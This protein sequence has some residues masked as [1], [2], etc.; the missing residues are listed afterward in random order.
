MVIIYIKK[1]ILYTY[2]KKHPKTQSIYESDFDE[3][4]EF[5]QDDMYKYREIL[6]VINSLKEPQRQ[7]MILR[8][9][10]DFTFKEIGEI[11][12]KSENYCRV[13]FFREKKKLVKQFKD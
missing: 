6:K 8:L 4:E 10:N 13:N 11:L 5:T 12:G 1:S 2:L 3:V 7:I 9:I